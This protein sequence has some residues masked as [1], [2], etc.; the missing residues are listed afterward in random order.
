LSGVADLIAQVTQG[1]G[2]G[3][4]VLQTLGTVALQVFQTQLARGLAISIEN[5]QAAERNA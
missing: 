5:F 1:L 3:I 4:G 2:G